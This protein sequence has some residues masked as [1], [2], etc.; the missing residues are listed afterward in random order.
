MNTPQ[1][2]PL[3]K[4]DL[5]EIQ[6][7]IADELQNQS[8]SVNTIKRILDKIRKLTTFP[9][10]GAPLSSIVDVETDYRYL[11]CGNYNVFYRVENDDIFIIRILYNRRDFL[12]ILFGDITDEENK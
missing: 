6:T 9:Y 10:M 5:M 4:N 11:I 2:S 3:S 7:Y 8:A 12:K 1:F